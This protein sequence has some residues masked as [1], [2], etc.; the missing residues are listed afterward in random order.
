MTGMPRPYS[1]SL[2][3]TLLLL[4]AIALVI[5][6]LMLRLSWYPVVT[7]DYTYF[8]RVWFDALENNPG[9]TAFVQPFS[10]YAPLYLYGLKFLTFFPINSLASIKTLSLLGD[11]GIAFIATR[12]IALLYRTRLTRTES[13]VLFA[14]FFM[15]PTVA[16]NSSFWGQS[17][18]LYALPVFAS[19]YYLLRDR[20]VGAATWFGVALAV[21]VQA[22]FFLPVLAGYL[23]QR[24]DT[25]KLL[26][27]PPLLFVVSVLPALLGGGNALYWLL[28]YV[29]QAGEYPYLSLS[30]PSIYAFAIAAVLSPEA[31]SLAF[32]S[33]IVAALV[34]AF[35][36]ARQAH[37]TSVSNT[38][39]LVSLSLLSVLALP[40]VL[41]RM[42]ERYFYLADIFSLLY[43]FA[44]PSRW[45]IPLLIVTSSFLSYLPYLSSQV[46]F[47][48][49]ITI[50]LRLP[51]TILALAL[52]LIA[53]DAIN[54]PRRSW[55]WL[56]FS[57]L[58][59]SS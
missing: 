9:L 27:I 57:G 45:Y 19:L 51:A 1:G 4:V 18:S 40:Y 48:S 43:A 31:I 5:G 52:V 23:W 14:V 25:R 22:I 29:K 41:P 16:M 54:L 21:K 36:I 39:A 33:G 34:I 20:P 6:G 13:A 56:R 7:S 26:A 2:A 11:L 37:R 8:T 59:A 53:L 32:W 12:T 58:R 46:P 49:G 47:L 28:I 3:Q 38:R 15:I 42:H 55:I 50:D 44:R 10:N 17:D 24:Q 30:A 35:I